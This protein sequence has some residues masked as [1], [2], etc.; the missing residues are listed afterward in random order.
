MPAVE[1]PRGVVE[2]QLAALNAHDLDALA[3][4]FDENLHS[5]DFVHPSQTFVGREQVRRNWGRV[6]SQVPDLKADVVGTAVEGNTVW[7][8]WRIYG[9]RRD[10]EMLD[11][12]GVTVS[13]VRGGRIVSSRRYLAPVDPSLVTVDESFRRLLE[14]R[15]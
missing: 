2:R 10:G 12:R 6:I 9:T 1:D 3:D 7:A 4:C 15:A 11:L 14:P 13:R 8:E 5:E